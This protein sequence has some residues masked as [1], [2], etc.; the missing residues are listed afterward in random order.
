M[1]HVLGHE[2][3]HAFQFDITGGGPTGATG[4]L[5]A[6]S[7]LP[8]WF[9]EGMA[10]YFSLGPDDPFTAMWMRD[11]VQHKFPTFAQLDDPRFFPYR[12]G[13]AL[14]AFVGGRW[15]DAA[16]A[17][18]LRAAAGR[19]GMD[20]AIRSVLGVTPDALVGAWQAATH[21]A[22]DP[23]VASTTPADSVGR[24]VVGP[25]KNGEGSEYN[26]SP[27]LSPDGRR[28]A[29][30]SNRGLFSI[31][32]YLADAATGTIE[33]RLTRTAV[34]PH[35]QS[36]EFINSASS[37][38]ASPTAGRHSSSLM[39]SWAGCSARCRSRTRARS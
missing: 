15:G 1:D 10:E 4:G 39:P 5:P 19:G 23:L 13:Q 18:L 31:D 26:V 29:F 17:Q 6:A 14:L 9:I 35:Y 27:A 20:P 3:V 28:L 2:L 30:L 37:S 32:L 25:E 7:Q 36:L 8:L 33:R 22:Y 12:F 16:V 24:R 38:P 34:D 11:A 21:A